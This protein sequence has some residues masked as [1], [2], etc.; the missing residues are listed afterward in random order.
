MAP[1]LPRAR[2]SGAKL[3]RTLVEVAGP[4]GAQAA[5]R[6]AEQAAVSQT[7]GE[8][9]GHWLGWTDAIALSAALDGEVV[10]APRPVRAPT[11]RGLNTEADR[12]RQQLAAAI[13]ADKALTAAA[14]PA[15]PQP[16]RRACTA[17]Q[18]AMAGGVAALRARLRTAL[19]GRSAAGA[20]LAAL[21]AVMEQ[22]LLAREQHA[23]SGVPRWL[24][25]RLTRLRED[26]PAVGG[27]LDDAALAAFSADVKAVL[28]AELDL[29]WEPINGLLAAWRQDQEDMKQA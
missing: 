7:F 3:V 27:V 11:T 6:A 17:Q 14:D 10:T 28:L 12:V 8:R 5:E 22:A 25:P 19:A 9:L 2:F 13:L 18:Q 20:Q 26:R 23:L 21:D 4:V 29:R 16:F 1:A 15:E 24:E